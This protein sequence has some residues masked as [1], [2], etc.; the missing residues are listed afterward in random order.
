MPLSPSFQALIKQPDQKKLFVS[1]AEAHHVPG[2]VEKVR[3][4]V[5]LHESFYLL[6]GRY[7][8]QLR[9]T[10]LHA[11]ELCIIQAATVAQQHQGAN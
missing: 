11:A 4:L 5:D 10:C 8:F 6:A 9:E 2:M 7:R 3:V 1:P